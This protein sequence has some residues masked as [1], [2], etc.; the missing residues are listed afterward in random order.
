MNTMILTDELLL[1]YKRCRRRTYLDVHGNPQQ[2]DPEKEFL[3]KLRR[4][5]QTH[6]NNVLLARSFVY[7]KPLGSWRNWSLNARQTKIM[8]Q[9]G[10]DCIYG[11]VLALNFTDWQSA[12]KLVNSDPSGSG[13]Q[14]SGETPELRPHLEAKKETLLTH[15][16]TEAAG[17]KLTFLAKPTLLIK[18]AGKSNFGDWSY[19]PVNIKLG[20]RPKSEYKLIAAFH[21]QML[22]AIQGTIPANSQLILRRQDSYFVNLEYWLPKMQTTVAD[23][24]AMLTELDEPE[25]F[26]SRQRCNLCHWYNHCY[27]IAKSQQHLSLIPGVTPKRYEYLSSQG[28]ETVEYLAKINSSLVNEAIDEDIINQLQ[29]QA[30]SILHDRAIL[31]STHKL[32]NR[33]EFP[34]NALELYFDIEAEPELNLDYLLGVLLVDRQNNTEVFYPLLAEKPE[35]E[36]IIWQQFLNLVTRYSDAPIFHFSE[37]EVDA[38]KRLAR[39]YG[40]PKT[41]IKIL[42]SRLVD[43]HHLVTESIV[44]PV[45]SYSLKSLANWIGFEWREQ[46]ASGEQSVCWYDRWLKT[47]DRSSLTSILRYNEDDCRATRYLKDWLVNFLELD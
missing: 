30:H 40:T 34:N 1:N 14:H 47:S 44:L 15:N 33:L 27:D 18:V 22:A 7:Q 6:I 43:L 45:E 21:A 38:I 28:I 2:R 24:I 16:L 10:V 3:L 20:R 13:G 42:L 39:L 46:G 29:Q 8:M 17:N 12:T 31:K 36:G 23:C 25:V 41:E 4:E 26:I 37:Y 35:D 32:A 5:S 9:Q 19:V 11:G